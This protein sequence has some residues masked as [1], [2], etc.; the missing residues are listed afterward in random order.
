MYRKEI[1]YDYETHDYA[2]YLDGELV[3]SA[4]T[5]RDAESALDQLIFELVNRQFFS[6]SNS[7]EQP[8]K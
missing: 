6:E 1:V 2:L 4:S 3:G 5:Y 7:D 8:A